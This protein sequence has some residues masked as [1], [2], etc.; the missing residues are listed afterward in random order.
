VCTNL[1]NCVWR[2][3]AFDAKFV[4]SLLVGWSLGVED[5][6]LMCSD[7]FDGN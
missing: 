5:K 4:V 2:V 1:H 3:A 6:C 7:V